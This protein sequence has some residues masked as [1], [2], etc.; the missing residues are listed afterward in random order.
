MENI[1]V[2]V[3]DSVRARLFRAEHVTGPLQEVRDFVNPDARLQERELVSDDK[4]R[5]A[6]ASA[7]G[8]VGGAGRQ[9][10]EPPS[11][12]EH[13]SRLFAH[14]V[15]GE[16]EKLRA[17][18]ELERLHVISD[19]EFLGRLRENYSPPLRKC[20][21][22]EITSHATQRRPEEIRELLPYRMH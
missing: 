14:E 12:K 2:V 5:T 19:P 15:I 3:A 18:G 6:A 4:G 16:I 13:Q 17:H 8:K 1:W 7:P 21:G 10:Y 11:E 20:V 22:A 9:T